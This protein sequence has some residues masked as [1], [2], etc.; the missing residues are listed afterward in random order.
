MVSP[1]LFANIP[2]D[3]IMKT[4]KTFTFLLVALLFLTES[5]SA[6]II[7]AE[8]R[9]IKASNSV[10][11]DTQLELA[12]TLTNHSGRDIEH[13]SF[14]FENSKELSL[15]SRISPLL[16][17]RIPAGSHITV[18]WKVEGKGQARQWR[19]G[20][21]FSLTG[22]GVVEDEFMVPLKVFSESIVSLD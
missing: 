19:K 17:E 18:N 16:V 5:A 13:A 22:Q 6:G 1:S 9:V 10:A 7:T 2:L 21:S 11:G 3:K 8:H 12:I 14:H 20:H 15:F 4:I